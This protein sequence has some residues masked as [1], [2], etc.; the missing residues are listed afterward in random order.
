MPWSQ[1]YQIRHDPDQVAAAVRDWIA[2]VPD[3]PLYRHLAFATADDP[4]LLAIVARVENVPPMNI[5]LGAVK[6]LLE[7]HHELAAWY[8]HLT[9]TPLEPSADATHAF[10]AFVLDHRDQIE[11]IGA[12]RR[13]QTNEVGRSAL[14]MPWLA[15]AATIWK[16][17]V[18]AVDLGASAGLNL[19]LDRFE[20]HYSDGASGS[21]ES[22]GHVDAPGH[23]GTL[24]HGDVKLACENRGGF[25]LPRTLPSFA[26]RTGIDLHPV[27]ATDPDQARWLA[28]LVWPEHTERLARLE[29]AISLRARTDITMVQGDAAQVLLDLDAMLPAGPMLVWHTIAVY[30]FSPVQRAALDAACEEIATRRHIARVGLE[31]T[32]G[33]PHPEVRV[34]LN[35]D[36]APTVAVA[37]SHGN[38]LDRPDRR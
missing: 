9:A 15:Q 16:A 4:D 2:F 31:P 5:F 17:P 38:W 3:S 24:G 6:Y 21:D 37:H 11:H 14:I 19:C 8:P 22:S 33:G 12:T 35:F 28:A 20:Y 18:H 26:S 13:T 32:A 1:W 23:G 25:D 34:G 30:Q 27:D 36:T 7:P 29:A 10:R